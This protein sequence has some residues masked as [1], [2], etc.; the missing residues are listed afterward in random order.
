MYLP[1]EVLR[2]QRNENITTRLLLTWRIYQ[3]KRMNLDRP[4]AETITVRSLLESCPVIPSPSQLGAAGQISKR[5][6]EPFEKALNRSSAFSWEYVGNP[7][8]S[9]TEFVQSKLHIHWQTDPYTDF[10]ALKTA[11]MRRRVK[12]RNWGSGG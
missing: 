11:K 1:H 3:H 4:N 5:I 2:T 7:P 6:I 8:N 10:P 12:G 9:Y